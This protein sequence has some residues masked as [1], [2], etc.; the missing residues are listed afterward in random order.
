MIYI[1]PP[2][3]HFSGQNSVD[4]TH[5]HTLCVNYKLDAARRVM[6]YLN[7]FPLLFVCMCVC[8]CVCLCVCVC[9]CVCLC[10]CPRD[11][12]KTAGPIFMKLVLKMVPQMEMFLLGFLTHML[13]SLFNSRPFSLIFCNKNCCFTISQNQL[14]ISDNSCFD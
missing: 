3:N 2:K 12:S 7:P 4:T 11:F 6:V 14:T 10:V 1:R 5:R 8:L 13:S 9:V